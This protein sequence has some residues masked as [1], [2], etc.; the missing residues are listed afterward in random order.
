METLEGSM[1]RHLSQESGPEKWRCGSTASEYHSPKMAGTQSCSSGNEPQEEEVG[2]L[3]PPGQPFKD[4]LGGLS[5]QTRMED[6]TTWSG[7]RIR[8]AGLG[9]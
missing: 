8:S 1:L 6:L 5:R 2:L 4:L 7:S 9:R 3:G